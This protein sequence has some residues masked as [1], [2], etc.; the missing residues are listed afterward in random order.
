MQDS[1][2]GWR[3]AF[4]LAPKSSDAPK[5][6]VDF[7][8]Y[9]VLGITIVFLQ[10]AFEFVAT[11]FNDV[12]IVISEFAPLLLRLALEF[13]PVSFDTVPVHDALLYKLTSSAGARPQ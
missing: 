9:L 8:P 11:S 12:K 13:L 2:L 6:R 7:G 5:P 10:A 1:L 4:G 3:P